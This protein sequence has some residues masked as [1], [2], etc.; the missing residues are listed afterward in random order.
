MASA[1][2]EPRRAESTFAT[3]R[4]LWPYMWPADRPDLKQRVVIALAILVLAKIA[5]VLVPYTYKWATDALVDW[6][7]LVR[8][9]EDRKKKDSPPTPAP[10]S[11]PAGPP[12]CARDTGPPSPTSGPSP[13]ACSPPTP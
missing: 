12:A 10:S 2:S 1:E 8:W 9:A 3:L 11:A 13:S 7:T 5:T 4:N 6:P